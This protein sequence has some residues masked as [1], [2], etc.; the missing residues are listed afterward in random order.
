MKSVDVRPIMI[1]RALKLS[2]TFHNKTNDIVK[3]HAL[4]DA[5]DVIGGMLGTTFQFGQLF[6]TVGNFQLN[7][8]M[9]KPE[10][11]RHPATVTTAPALSHNKAKNHIVA[12]TAGKPYLH[13]LGLTD[14]NG[15]VF[16]NAHD[17]FRQI[18]KYIEI[19]D[20]LIK[21]LPPKDTLRIAD[22]G[23]GKG[24]LTFAL[25]D[26]VVNTMKLKAEMVGVEFRKELV[27]FGNTIARESGFAGLRFVEGSIADYNCAGT[28]VVI[29]LHA[30]DTA[31]DDALFKAIE[32]KAELIIVAPCC[33]KQV[34]REMVISAN[35]PLSFMLQYGTY[36]ERMAE[37]LTDSLRAHLLQFKGYSTHVFE[38]I[39]DAH[40]PKNVMIVAS[41]TR[42]GDNSKALAAI[43]HIQTSFGIKTQ[44][45][46]KLLGL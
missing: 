31:T 28:D 36:A 27:A 8:N 26:H 32:A 43:Q 22:M 34:R 10:V 39:S 42:G 4:E 35:H 29:A 1:K 11:T 2:F 33:H 24:Y 18:N 16:K 6:T 12:A 15:T 19:V 20:G 40:T 23:A 14:A 21:K 7:L 44:H 46:A 25:Y 41:K 45:L 5:R 13:A 17:K 30:C 37:M 9:A 3:N 38:F